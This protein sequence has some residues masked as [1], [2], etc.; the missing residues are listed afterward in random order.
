MK[1]FAQRA[2]FP[3][4]AFQAGRGTCGVLKRAGF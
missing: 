1:F 2:D 4:R 3:D